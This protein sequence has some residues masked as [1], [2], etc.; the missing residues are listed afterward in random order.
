ML[1]SSVF[2]IK[3]LFAMLLVLPFL[4]SA[5]F[6]TFSTG[7]DLENLDYTLIAPTAVKAG[8]SY[9]ITFEIRNPGSQSILVDAVRLPRTLLEGSVISSVNPASTGT[10]EGYT[11]NAYGFTLILAPG[12]SATVV[13]SMQ[14]VT[15]GS[16]SGSVSV[17]MG[18]EHEDKNISVTVGS[19]GTSSSSSGGTTGLADNQTVP[20]LG[21]NM[22][23]T[24]DKIP[25]MGVVQILARIRISGEVI[26]GWTGSGTI[27]SP[28]GLI[29]TNA[30]VAYDTSYQI[31][32][33]VI[34]MTEEQDAPPVDRYLAKVIQVDTDLDLAVLYIASDL[35]GYTVDHASLNLPAVPLGDS[36]TLQLGDQ[37]TIL[38]YPGIGGETITL[39]R[40]EVSGFTAETGYGNRAFIKTSATIAGGNSGGLAVNESGQLVG[41]PTQVGAGDDSDIVDCRP[42]AD[43]NRDGYIDDYDACIPIG[44]YINALR[45]IALAM[46]L[47]DAARSG[48]MNVTAENAPMGSSF[49]PSGQTIYQD[50]FSDPDSGWWVEEYDEGYYRYNNGRYEVAV[51]PEQY[52]FYDYV[53]DEFQD[54]QISVDYAFI[55]PTG[56]GE[57]AVVCNYQDD[58]NFVILL[59]SEDGYYAIYKL[60]NDE[61]SAL[62]DYTYTDLIDLGAPG[63]ITATC[64][65]GKY[66]LAN[67]NVLLVEVTDTTFASGAVG[68]MASTY[69]TP[70]LIVAFDN[71]IVRQK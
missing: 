5:C 66:S 55:Q 20:I 40:G 10:T 33:L 22:P 67:N 9:F 24:G 62:V 49:A 52:Y 25:Y 38:G 17:A 53:P 71:F 48:Q 44:G 26:D 45:P 6:P 28:D 64:A 19:D 37:I 2:S 54:V 43:T 7:T 41:V 58:Q 29:L 21:A 27:I 30:H 1:I 12:E 14:A 60:Y 35:N 70:N 59:I 69:N 68:L 57:A 15:P 46:P 18:D 8:E 23:T 50:N 65:D 32:Q 4:L 11:Q 16:Y 61:W 42:L 3:R 51:F 36:N 13:F 56:E 47:I 63:T 31:E 34:R 39:T